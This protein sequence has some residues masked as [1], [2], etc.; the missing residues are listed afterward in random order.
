[1]RSSGNPEPSG[2]VTS[3]RHPANADTEESGQRPAKAQAE[4]SWSDK[5]KTIGGLVAVAVGVVVVG[6]IAVIALV[7]DS[8]TSATIASSATGRGMARSVT[9]KTLTPWA[10]QTNA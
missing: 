2:G 5:V 7:K 9:S 6:L 8:D 1:M 4:D 3:R 10:S